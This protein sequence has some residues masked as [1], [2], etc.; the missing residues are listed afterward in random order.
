MVGLEFHVTFAIANISV[1]CFISIFPQNP[2]ERR[3]SWGESV[4]SM[5][6]PNMLQL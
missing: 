3:S 6:E 2:E 5:G 1:V 4:S